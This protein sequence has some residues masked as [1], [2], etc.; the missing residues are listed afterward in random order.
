MRDVCWSIS[1]FFF[2]FNNTL[3]SPERKETKKKISVY[4]GTVSNIYC[5]MKYVY[6]QVTF[7]SKGESSHWIRAFL[8]TWKDILE[9]TENSWYWLNSQ[10]HKI[11]LKNRPFPARQHNSCGNNIS[12]LKLLFQFPGV[13][14]L[15][16][17]SNW[18]SS[19]CPVS[20]TFWFFLLSTWWNK[21]P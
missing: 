16:E 7:K 11:T 6:W 1:F 13:L 2:S 8:G 21:S 5:A 19:E 18:A 4:R 12:N 14:K 20:W 17:I 10:D 9:D 15:K 3:L